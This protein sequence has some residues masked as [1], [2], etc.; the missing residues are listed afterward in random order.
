MD[1]FPQAPDGK[2]AEA[3]MT[4]GGDPI[5]PTSGE[6]SVEKYTGA[7][8]G[9]IGVWKCPACAIENSTPFEDGCPSCGAGT[10]KPFH[11]DPTVQR[12]QGH[13]RLRGRPLDE[14]GAIAFE[15]I[16]FEPISS[17]EAFSAW[18]RPHRANLTPKMEMLLFE[19]WQAAIAW[20]RSQDRTIAPSTS[21]YT[22]RTDQVIVPRVLV[23][24]IIERLE[25]MADLPDDQQSDE[26]LD[27][28]RQLKE[29]LS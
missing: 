21:T 27:L 29:L 4:R 10:A 12:R 28:I 6:L 2:K 17:E 22:D 24:Q 16:A 7:G 25:G 8:L 9:A 14:N 3:P 11:V 19:A 20:F 1:T 5:G 26:L 13:S 15:P 18:L 23:G